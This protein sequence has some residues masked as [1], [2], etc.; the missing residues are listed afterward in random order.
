MASA[1]AVVK[2]TIL[3]LHFS[4]S[5]RLPLHPAQFHRWGG[6]QQTDQQ[7]RWRRCGRRG[8]GPG[9]RDAHHAVHQHRGG[10]GWRHL[11]QRPYACPDP[12]HGGDLGGFLTWAL[13]W[14]GVKQHPPPWRPLSSAT[15]ARCDHLLIRVL[16]VFFGFPSCSEW[17]QRYVI[18]IFN[19]RCHIFPSFRYG[20][21][22]IIFGP[23]FTDFLSTPPH[24]CR[25]IYSA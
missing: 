22:D 12:G 21:F 13:I 17:T 4:P 20:N 8:L 14:T 16:V 9:Q 5:V 6:G 7:R 23:C 2:I 19:L 24:T 1:M 11:V 10:P 15:R 18:L 25:V 3:K